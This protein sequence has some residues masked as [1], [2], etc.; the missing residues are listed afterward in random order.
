MKESM[1]LI[2]I[3]ILILANQILIFKYQIEEDKL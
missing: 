1:G 3:I 2:F